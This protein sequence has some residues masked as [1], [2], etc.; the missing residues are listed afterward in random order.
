MQQVTINS[1][2]LWQSLMALGKIGEQDNGGM[3]RPA[4][5]P[6]DQQ[7][8]EWL[9]SQM[10]SMGLEVKVDG[11]LNVIGRLK[12]QSP[13]TEQ[14]VAMGSHIDTVPNGGKFDG[15]YGVLAAL[16]CVKSLQENQVTLP[17]DV[18]VISFC[19]EEAAH[20]AGTVGSRAMMGRLLPGEL[21][22][23]KIKG[24]KPF[25]YFL[26]QLG[27]SFAA[28]ETAQRNADEFLCFLEAHIE[29]GKVLE[30]RQQS[31]GVVTGIVGV[32]RYI[33]TV[34]GEAAHAG[35]TPMSMRKDALV[36][37]APVFT[38]IPQWV[39]EQNPDMVGTIGQVTV[40]PGAS[41]V[42][43][44]ECRFLVELRS[45]QSQDMQVVRDKLINYANLRHGWNIETIYEK[46][47]VVLDDHMISCLSVVTEA[48]QLPYIT[49]ASGAGH[50][51]QSF[52]PSV[53]T[54]MIFIPC[55]AG[56]SHNPK[57]WITEEDASNGCQVLMDAVRHLA[58]QV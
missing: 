57:E 34:T 4:L 54:G 22:K 27:H 17:F 49:M 44:K 7:A 24:E 50:D 56:V 39:H 38:L 32:Y 53:P 13:K 40:L 5:S 9:V 47:S 30:S 42:V 2:R 6:E 58:T 36:E 28:V 10:E 18:E 16:E 20:N 19:D 37:A 26:E 35:T 25:R 11:A 41:N 21:E 46:D 33:V 12:S 51:A 29:Q 8:R 31:I 3:Y 14:V 48:A 43:P 52:A 55:L 1:E 23:A 45:Q 15:A